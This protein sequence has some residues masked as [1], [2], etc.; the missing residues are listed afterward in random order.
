MSDSAHPVIVIGHKNPDSDSICGAIAC[1]R[2]KRDLYNE[3]AIPYRVGNVNAQTSF[4]LSYFGVEIPRFL[5]DVYPKISDIMIKGE[6]LIILREDE[7][8]R[9]AREIITRNRFSFL[10]VMG[11]DGRCAGRLTS[12]RLADLTSDIAGLARYENAVIDI[13]A[14]LSSVKGKQVAGEPLPETFSGTI[15]LLGSGETK[16]IEDG[17]ENGVQLL[18]LCGGVAVGPDILARVEKHGAAAM[19]VQDNILFVAVELL[20]S[21][22]VKH[23]MDREY[24][25]FKPYD[26]VRDVKREIE[27]SNEGGFIVTD[28]EGSIKGV[29]ARINFLRQSKFRLILVDHNEF[30]QAVDGVEEAEIVEIIDHHRLGIKSTDLPIQFINKAVGSTCTIIAELYSNAGRTPDTSTAGLMLAAVLSDTVLLKSPTTTQLDREMADWLASIAGLDLN[31][32]GGEMLAA[33]SSLKEMDP[34]RIISQDQ[35]TYSE[36]GIQFS[37]SQVEVVGFSQFEDL[38]D[39]LSRALEYFR[40]REAVDFCCLMVTDV[41]HAS[42]LVLCTGDTVIIEAITYPR[43]GRKMFEMKGVLSRKKQMLPYF[44]VLIRRVKR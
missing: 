40:K 1:A 42:S 44:I 13:P 32:F 24:M 21:M 18:I 22:P 16:D 4:I 14:F 39:E 7:P 6:E 43:A 8:L 30:A 29:I 15:A 17:L 35:K 25:S 11:I 12:I 33:G 41:T 36:S 23:Y 31:R 3:D 19:A 34:E 26:L 9:R 2:L 38:R 27:K 10:P 37:I 5:T 20:L 28:D